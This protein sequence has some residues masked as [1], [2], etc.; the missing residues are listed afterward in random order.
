MADHSESNSSL[1]CIASSESYITDSN[2][3]EGT[4]L[5]NLADNFQLMRLMTNSPDFNMNDELNET[6]LDEIELVVWDLDLTITKVHTARSPRFSKDLNNLRLEDIVADVELFRVINQQLLRLGK[7][8][9]IASFGRKS[10]ILDLMTRIF[11]L[12]NCSDNVYINKDTLSN[13]L[14]NGAL[15]DELADRLID[16][17]N[18]FNE[19]NVV[20]P[21]DFTLSS[22]KLIDWE[23]NYEPPNGYGKADLLDLLRNRLKV[24][25]SRHCLLFDDSIINI[26]NCLSN[27]YLTVLILPTDGRYGFCRQVDSLLEMMMRTK[28]IGEFRGIW[29]KFLYKWCHHR[30]T[31]LSA[32]SRDSNNNCK[33]EYQ[34]Q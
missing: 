11:S 22:G 14:S 25:Q 3:R 27:G 30:M 15:L 23:E 9:A 7:K 8:V 20:T 13:E 19:N 12:P 33:Y 26:H 2:S 5:N 17:L 10:L 4:D 32:D 6:I 28:S 24:P 1:S 31:L 34:H 18:V 16:G 21:T 29:Y